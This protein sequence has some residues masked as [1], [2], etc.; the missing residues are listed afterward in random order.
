M[1]EEVINQE[2]AVRKKS[3]WDGEV[4]RAIKYALISASAERQRS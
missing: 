3:F 1:P 2:I 4:W